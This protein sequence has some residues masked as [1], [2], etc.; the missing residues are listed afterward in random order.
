MTFT[1]LVQK[2]PKTQAEAM[3]C[4]AIVALSSHPQ[5]ENVDFW[6]IFEHLE[7]TAQHW[8]DSYDH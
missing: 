3:L 1:E 6:R 2:T 4:Q 8:K 7:K 5:F